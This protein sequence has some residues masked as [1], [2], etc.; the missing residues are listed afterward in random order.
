MTTDSVICGSGDD[1]VI[2]AGVAGVAPGMLNVIAC[3]PSAVLA[4]V[5]RLA[6]RARAAIVRCSHHDLH[7]PAN[8]AARREL[9]R[10]AAASVA[11][12]VMK[13]PAGSIAAV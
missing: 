11:V 6:E 13:S 4:W 12:A 9:G 10:V 2:S 3:V 7:G 5:I 1:T 8:L